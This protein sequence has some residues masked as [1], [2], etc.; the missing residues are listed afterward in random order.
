MCGTS[1]SSVT[2]GKCFAG[3]FQGAITER[4]VRYGGLLTQ[5]RRDA[6]CAEVFWSWLAARAR[7]E[8]C[9]SC[10]D[11]LGGR[12]S[13][14]AAFVAGRP[15]VGPYQSPVFG[16]ARSPS[17]PVGARQIRSCPRVV[18]V[19]SHHHSR[20]SADIRHSS[21]DI[22]CP[23]VQLPTNFE[24]SNFQTSNFKHQTLNLPRT[25]ADS[26]ELVKY[27]KTRVALI[28]GA[29]GSE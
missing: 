16:K 22:R 18:H 29:P 10:R 3:S 28:V 2:S 4:A 27:R 26:G 25:C 20:S 23:T 7:S 8:T 14:R 9:C 19:V 13:S 12:A 6:E 24:L 17:A 11:R 15:V 21:P 1:E 5:R